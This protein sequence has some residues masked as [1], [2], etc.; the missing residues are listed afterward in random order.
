MLCQ[1][2]CTHVWAFI[3]TSQNAPGPHGLVA[4]SPTPWIYTTDDHILHG[5]P[6]AAEFRKGSCQL[7][8]LSEAR[9]ACEAGTAHTLLCSSTTAQD[10]HCNKVGHHATRVSLLCNLAQSWRYSTVMQHYCTTSDAVLPP[11]QHS[12]NAVL[13]Q[14]LQH[15]KRCSAMTAAAAPPTMKQHSPGRLSVTAINRGVQ[16]NTR[17]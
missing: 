10:Q 5:L 15:H 2:S 7:H 14:Q 1:V 6:A 17:P 13:S 4:A 11:L 9:L 8:A 3:S 12:N 16:A